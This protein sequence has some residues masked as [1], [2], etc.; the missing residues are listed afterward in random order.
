LVVTP[1]GAVASQPGVTLVA[2]AFGPQGAQRLVASRPDGTVVGLDAAGQ[3]AFFIELQAQPTL[4]ARDVDGDGIDELILGIQGL[5][6]AT[7]ALGLP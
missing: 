3:P 6:M 2:G 7:V 1:Q 4:G 5:G